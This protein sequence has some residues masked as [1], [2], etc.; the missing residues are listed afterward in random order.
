MATIFCKT[1]Q[2][3]QI[4]SFKEDTNSKNCLASLLAKNETNQAYFY[5]WLILFVF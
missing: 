1:I 2:M 3:W 4:V 5:K